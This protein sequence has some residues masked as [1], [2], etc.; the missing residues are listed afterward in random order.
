M[1]LRVISAFEWWGVVAATV[2]I[3]LVSMTHGKEQK[4]KTKTK[5]KTFSGKKQKWWTLPLYL[6]L[7]AAFGRSP[8]ATTTATATTCSTSLRPTNFKPEIDCCPDIACRR[9]NFTEWV[10]L[11]KLAAT[12]ILTKNLILINFRD[13]LFLTM[14][15]WAAVVTIM[16]MAAGRSINNEWLTGRKYIYNTNSSSSNSNS[17]STMCTQPIIQQIINHSAVRQMK[18]TFCW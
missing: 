1:R 9:N 13:I 4:T 14:T 15:T 10:T 17:N 7:P 8:T 3:G 12:L 18:A 5:Q 6:S 2:D 16:V 11:T